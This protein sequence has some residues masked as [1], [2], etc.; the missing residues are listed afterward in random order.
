ML[1]STSRRAL[2][3]SVAA[4]TKA[5]AA[6]CAAPLSSMSD[7]KPRNY[8]EVP[9]TVENRSSAKDAL[10]KSCYFKIDFGISEEATVYEAVQRFAAYNIGAL[11]VTN[12]DEKV[13]GIVSERDYVSKVAL[14]GKASKSTTVKEIATMGANLV[15]ASKSDTMQECMAKMVARDIR[16]LPVVDEEKGQ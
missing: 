14:L 2:R 5:C 11:A 7:P 4:K 1:A 6:P 16:H 8:G 13:I 15:V 12:A 10:Q 9:T 3:T